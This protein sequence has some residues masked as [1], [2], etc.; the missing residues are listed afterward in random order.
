MSHNISL[1]FL[2]KWLWGEAVLVKRWA[3]KWP[4]SFTELPK[5]K[6][7]AALLLG[8]CLSGNNSRETISEVCRRSQSS[9]KRNMHLFASRRHTT[10][11]ETLENE[12]G[13]KYLANFCSCN[14]CRFLIQVNQSD[15]LTNRLQIDWLAE[16]TLMRKRRPWGRSLILFYLLPYILRVGKITK[17][18]SYIF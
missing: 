12:Y 9:D 11:I 16:R 15:F 4:A 7:L 10:R 18:T 14:Y 1:C 6:P 17:A 2:F 13:K 3:D 5:L 8:D